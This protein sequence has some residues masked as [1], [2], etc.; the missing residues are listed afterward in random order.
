MTVPARRDE[1][2]PRPWEIDRRKPWERQKGETAR[3]YRYFTIYRDLGANRSLAAVASDSG[4]SKARMEQLSR[5]YAWVERVGLWE[6]ELDRRNR[7]DLDRL[8]REAL[9]RHRGA[10]AGLIGKGMQRLFGDPEE[11]VAALDANDLAPADVV[12]FITEGIRAERLAYG[13]PTDL[14]RGAFM[15]SSTKVTE[16]AGE[17]IE[18]AMR[19]LP[20]E[21]AAAFVRDVQAL[22]RSY[23]G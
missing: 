6:D 15:V 10:A 16:V 11:D 23:G 2:E 19:H 5:K 20:E 21:R 12:R 7:E 14:V 22:A 18:I 13:E 4:V 9:D 17:I 8:R 3:A 1:D